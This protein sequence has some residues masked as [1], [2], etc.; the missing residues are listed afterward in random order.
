MNAGAMEMQCEGYL[1]DETTG[2]PDKGI[3]PGTPFDHLPGDRI[4]RVLRRRRNEF[5]NR[6]RIISIPVLVIVQR[7]NTGRVRS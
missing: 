4:L 3:L 1:Y 7:E 5:E 6:C 2:G